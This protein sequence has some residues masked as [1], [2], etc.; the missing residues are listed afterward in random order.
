MKA[1]LANASQ[2]SRLLGA[3]LAFEL[4]KDMITAGLWMLQTESMIGRIARLSSSP[5]AFACVW[6]ALAVLVV[7]YLLMQATDCGRA[8][9]ARITRLACWAILASG[10]FWVYLG[11]LSKNLDYSYV[12]KIFLFHGLTCIAMAATLAN[13][14]NTSQRQLQEGAA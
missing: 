8:H 11:Y 12:T 5:D 1:A 3:V 9:Q 10:V 4:G 2:S 13:S 6:M 7:P 14:L